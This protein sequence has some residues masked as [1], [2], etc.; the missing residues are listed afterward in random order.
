[1]C[2]QFTLQQASHDSTYKW[3]FGF[4]LQRIEYHGYAYC[5]FNPSQPRDV[6]YGAVCFEGEL[7]L[8]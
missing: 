7:L 8:H 6:A 3:V 5:V 4:E 1:M 2:I